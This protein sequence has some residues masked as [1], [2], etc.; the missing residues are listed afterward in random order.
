[1]KLAVGL[2]QVLGPFLHLDFQIDVDLLKLAVIRGVI[3]KHSYLVGD[4][5]KAGD[6]L[7]TDC[8]FSR[9]I[10]VDYAHGLIS[11]DQG[12][13]NKGPNLNRLLAVFA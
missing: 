13:A 2:F 12:E 10:Q 1:L 8:S 3:E 5:G 7:L 6:V 11:N 4:N 9:M